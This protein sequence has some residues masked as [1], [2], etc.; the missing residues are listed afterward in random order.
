MPFIDLK[1]AIASIRQI[2]DLRKDEK[3]NSSPPFFFIVGAGIS[4][5]EIPLAAEIEEHCRKAAEK[6]GKTASPTSIT[7]IDT[8]SHWISMAYPSAERRQAYLRRL[9]Q[10]QPISKAN[11]RLAH[12]LLNRTV[13][14][15]VFTPNFDDML[16]KALQLFGERPLVCDHPLT[17]NRMRIQSN[18]IQV[19]HVHGSYWH[20]DCCNLKDDVEGRAE[21]APM[22]LTIYE[23]MRDL[24]PIV[25]GYSG[26][27]GDI[28]MSAI[29]RRF[30]AG[31][32]PNPIFWFCFRRDSIDTLPKWL[33]NHPDVL[34]VLPEE[35]VQQAKLIP[36]TESSLPSSLSIVNPGGAEKSGNTFDQAKENTLPAVRVFDALVSGFNLPTPRLTQ[37]PLSFYAEQLRSQL[38]TKSQEEAALDTFYSFHTVISRVEHAA[39]AEQTKAPDKLQALRDA[40]GKADY[41]GAINAAGQ[42]QLNSL[43]ANALRELTFVLMDAC[44][45]LYDNS[46]DEITGYDLIVRA[47]TILA[48][49]GPADPIV[50]EKI[51]TALF[52]KGVTLGDLD[53]SEEAIAVYDDAV[54]RFADAR[55]LAFRERVAMALFNKG[56]RLGTLGRKEE[57]IAVYDDVVNR[58]ADAREPALQ[59][60]VAMTLVNKGIVLGTL[61]RSE[62]AIAVYDDVVSRF[63]VFKDPALQKQ[64]A[65]A[66]VGKGFRLGTLNRSE[67]AIAVYDDVV[68]RF[69]DAKEPTRQEQV[70]VALVNKGVRLGTLNRSEEEIAVYDDV[71]SR[72]ADAKESALQERVAMALVNKGIALGTLK[73]S[74]EE[75]A[76]YDDVVSRFADAKEPAL[77]EQV[78]KAIFY[79]GMTYESSGNKEIAFTNYEEILARFGGD[80]GS[81]IEELVNKARKKLEGLRGNDVSSE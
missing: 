63:A 16:S 47:G 58:F 69:A 42:I 50:Q 62:E 35:A 71:V 12:L 53:R 7:P 38:V 46:V 20:Y 40:M 31:R 17:V 39:E 66:L 8:Y 10:D 41:R 37:N 30:E 79:R 44:E 26:W 25:V 80:K 15:T 29:W 72:F 14:R 75:I 22:T 23:Q 18:D 76:V 74:E 60:Q 77:R 6:Y 55:E 61:N 19:I 45:G 67:E 73:K 70:A 1:D 3:E 43:P 21:N 59:K 78:A 52:N 68:S 34:F 48:K 5:P 24:S 54:S 2:I 13:A 4:H 56:F 51:A 32:L 81:E 65:R 36:E 9:M 33:T 49:Q 57:A 11:L 28:I 64:V 27:E